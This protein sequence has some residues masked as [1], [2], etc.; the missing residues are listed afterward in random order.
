M[1][2]KHCCSRL[3]AVAWLAPRPLVDREQLAP[4][5]A[6]PSALPGEPFVALPTK[7]VVT[8][9]L[10]L[11]ANLVLGIRPVAEQP[12]SLIGTVLS[13]SLSLTVIS[14]EHMTCEAADAD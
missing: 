2:R 1:A 6:L 12:Q 4:W 14:R 5:S 7:P 8:L 10:A 11:V 9:Y 13:L 3:G